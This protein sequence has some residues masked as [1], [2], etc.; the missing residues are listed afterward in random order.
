MNVN[1]E[2]FLF[3]SNLELV[4]EGIEAGVT[5]IVVDLETK[6]KANRQTS[7]NTQ[8]NR[9]RISDIREIRQATRSGIICRVNGGKFLSK[10]EIEAAIDAGANEILVPMVTS[11]TEIDE[12]VATVR[13][14]ACIS[15]MIETPEAIALVKEINQY[16]IYRVFVG[17]NDLSIAFSQRNLFLPLL[18]GTVD[19]I[20]NNIHTRFGVAGLTHPDAGYP[21]KCRMLINEMKRLNCTFGFLRRSYYADL[22]HYSQSDIISS[23]K[24]EFSNPAINMPMSTCLKNYILESHDP[25]LLKTI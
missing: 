19:H 9:H 17:L 11:L 14:R 5:G 16:P 8:V 7:Y 22:E 21:V 4:L 20:R 2:Y 10:S 25:V 12:V 23:L 6:G 15:L 1:F 13:N 3:Y 24:L 18:D